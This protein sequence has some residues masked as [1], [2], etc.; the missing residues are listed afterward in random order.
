[1]RPLP[2]QHPA[3]WRA[4]DSQRAAACRAQTGQGIPTGFPVLDAA[5]PDGGWPSEGLVEILVSGWGCGDSDLMVPL[6]HHL[7]DQHRWQVWINPPW[8]PYAPGLAQQGVSVNRALLL[9][10]R[11]DNDV[12]WAME[13]CLASGSSSI[14][15]AWPERLKPSQ[16]RR[17][18][19]AAQ[20]GQALGFMVRPQACAQQ[21][22]PAPL[23][24]EVGPVLPD[25]Q[26]QVRVLKRRGGWG[27]DWLTLTPPHQSHSPLADLDQWM[28][29]ALP[30]PANIP[31]AIT[32]NVPMSWPVVSPM[33]PP[34][35]TPI[36]GSP[37]Y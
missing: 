30:P 19:L 29:H 16:I 37:G 21:P 36:Q 25:Q 12:L 9:E 7:S 10:C 6:L 2:V 32:R 4:A 13:Q 3:I 28:A 31:A 34:A 14:V 22:S 27:S 5:L 33:A 15:Q 26:I 17:L 20:K 23:R 18:H 35:R 11:Q 8:L 1:M 24:L